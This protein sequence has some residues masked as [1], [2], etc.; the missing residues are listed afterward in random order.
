M[1]MGMQCAVHVHREMVPQEDHHVW[2]LGDGGPN[3]AAN[4][5][6]V[7]AN[8]HY[9]IH[10]YLDLLREFAPGAAEDSTAVPYVLRR[11]FGARARGLA[12]DGW[13]QIVSAG[14][15]TAGAAPGAPVERSRV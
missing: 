8:A 11:Q 14:T 13:R 1:K 5:V 9:S 10:A 3:V 2:P 7:C 12:L 15:G 4:K 6:R